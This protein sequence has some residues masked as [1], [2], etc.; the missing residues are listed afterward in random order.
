MPRLWMMGLPG[1]PFR[2]MRE[3]AV[4]SNAV[5]HLRQGVSE[6]QRLHDI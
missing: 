3:D 5:I 2:R 1:W 6:S 4:D